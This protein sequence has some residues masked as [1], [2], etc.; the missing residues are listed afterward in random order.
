MI[1]QIYIVPTVQALLGVGIL[2][3][4]EVI[5]GDLFLL[6]CLPIGM[7]WMPAVFAWFSGIDPLVEKNFLGGMPEALDEEEVRMAEDGW[8][9]G[10]AVRYWHCKGEICEIG[11]LKRCVPKI[12]EWP[13]NSWSIPISKFLMTSSS[14]HDF[15]I[16]IQSNFVKPFLFFGKSLTRKSENSVFIFFPENDCLT[17]SSS[18]R[19]MKFDPWRDGSSSLWSNSSARRR[20]LVGVDDMGK[21]KH[22]VLPGRFSIYSYNFWANQSNL[23]WGHTRNY[24]NLPSTMIQCLFMKYG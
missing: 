3:G 11:H 21:K 16:F 5:L 9:N 12:P 19:L 4:L 18:T 22:G 8:R 15:S 23:S 1:Q 24:S 14:E 10:K 2:R 6:I 20:V 7:C 17:A 13:C